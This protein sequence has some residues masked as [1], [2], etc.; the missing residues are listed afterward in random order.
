MSG[1]SSIRVPYGETKPIPPLATPVGS[2]RQTEDSI[3]ASGITYTLLKHNLYAEVIPMLI[4]DR[5]QLLKTKMIYLPT[6]DGSVSFAPKDD[7]AEVMILLNRQRY[8]NRTLA[9]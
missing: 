2:H 1:T 9:F 8:K 6:A 7:L 3:K 5:D 4:G